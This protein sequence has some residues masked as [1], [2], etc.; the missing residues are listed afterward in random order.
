MFEIDLSDSNPMPKHLN[1][2]RQFKFSPQEK[3]VWAAMPRRTLCAKY[4]KRRVGFDKV[5]EHI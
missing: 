5:F 4:Q 2:E 1:P 3:A